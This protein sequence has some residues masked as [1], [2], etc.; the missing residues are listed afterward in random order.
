MG[1]TFKIQAVNYA[2]KGGGVDDKR[3][4]FKTTH[5][6]F[7]FF[8]NEVDELARQ[9]KALAAKAHDTSQSLEPT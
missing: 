4:W 2:F 7:W 9:V 1:Y 6:W 5:E 3:C 8:F